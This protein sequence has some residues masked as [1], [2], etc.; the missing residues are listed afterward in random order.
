MDITPLT[1]SGK[2]LGELKD[3]S[4][5]LMKLDTELNAKMPTSISQPVKDLLFIV[6]SFYSNRIEGNPTTPAE[7]LKIHNQKNQLEDP[8]ISD[9]LLQIKR[10]LELQMLFDGKKTNPDQMHT[11]EYIKNMHKAFYAGMPDKFLNI[12]GK[13]GK[14]IRLV[15]GEYRQNDV[16]VGTHLAPSPSLIE[17]YMNW[18]CDMLHPRRYHGTEKLLAAAEVHHR[19]AYIHPFLD[20]N[21]RVGRLL[22]DLYMEYSG[23]GGYRFWTMSRGFARNTSDYYHALSRA[24]MVRQ[25]TTDGRGILSDKGLIE[26]MNYFL[27]TGLDQVNFFKRILDPHNLSERINYYFTMRSKGL[28]HDSDGN[29][30]PKLKIEAREIYKLILEA[31][32]PMT[33]K[34]IYDTLGKSD[35]TLGPVVRQMQEEGFVDAKPKQP[36]EILI[37]NQSIEW[38]FPSLLMS[39]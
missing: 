12:K 20:G 23:L 26:F 6:N 2:G 32:Q 11:T 1:F 28:G 7:V 34:E 22:T 15:P 21:G 25:G 29:T 18:L 39:N 17:G 38:L 16:T 4:F 27:D 33:R 24:D 37:S 30:L 5:N 13:N 35:K 9:E 8:N 36:V 14:V 31:R 3:K 19:F 10:H